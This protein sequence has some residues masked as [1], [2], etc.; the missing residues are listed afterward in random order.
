V[1]VEAKSMEMKKIQVPSA[2][3]SISTQKVK[4]FVGDIKNEIHK[5]H[6]TS[7]EELLTYTKIVIITTFMFGMAIYFVDMIIQGTLGGLSFLMR[8]IAG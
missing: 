6:W 1:G 4:E 7:R 2:E 3:K 8:L 5:V